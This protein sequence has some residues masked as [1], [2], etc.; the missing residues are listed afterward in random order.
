MSFRKILGQSV[1]NGA[2]CIQDPWMSAESAYNTSNTDS[3]EL[4]DFF[5]VITAINYVGHRACVHGES[6]GARKERKHVEIANL[7]IQKKL[8]ECQESNR[9]HRETV[10]GA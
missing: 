1:N 4:V 7:A 10:N 2:L 9:L 8:A 3:R 5:L 6:A